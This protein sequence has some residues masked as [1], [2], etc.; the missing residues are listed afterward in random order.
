[1]RY[2]DE[3]FIIYYNECDKDY[4]NLLVKLLMKDLLLFVISSV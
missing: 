2:E 3:K 4:I 1:M